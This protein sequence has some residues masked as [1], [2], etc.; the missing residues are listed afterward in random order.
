MVFLI[1]Q[2]IFF[3][4]RLRLR[5]QE[6]IFTDEEIENFTLQKI[7]TILNANNRSLS[8]FPG[9]PQVNHELI[10]FGRNKLIADERRYMVNEERD[11]W[12]TLY[13]GLNTSQKEVY[14]NIMLSVD[15]QNRGL[16]LFMEVVVPVKT[17]L[18]RT[19][20]AQIRS[21]G[22]I[23][24]FVA[25]SGIASLVLSGGRTLH[26]RFRIPVEIDNES[27]CGIDVIS[28]LVE[29]I[30]VSELIIWDEAPLQHRHAF[31][32]VDRTFRDIC[33]LDKPIAETQVLGGKA[34]VLGGDL[35]QILL[36]IKNA[37]RGDVVVASVNKSAAIWGSCR[38]FVLSVN[39]RLCDP[40]LDVADVDQMMCFNKWY[41][42]MGDGTLLAIKLAHEDDATGIT[43]PDDLLIPISDNP[44]TA[45]VSSTYP[46]LSNIINDI[47][48][49]KE[50]C[51]LCPTND[52]VDQINSHELK[53]TPSDLVELYSTDE[54]C[55][56]TENLEEMKIMYPPEF[57]NTLRFSGV[58]NHKLELKV[59]AQSYYYV[60]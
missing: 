46:D 11:L 15:A 52:V 5:N 59:G 9:L 37:R 29:L 3:N 8:N 44:T 45:I 43:I 54:I 23:V 51:I 10:Q 6:V 33:K 40:S 56:T 35:R 30:R 7:E 42:D 41:L 21:L 55:P 25:S 39:M 57:L 36:V 32:S 60:I 28:D 50:R 48:Y 4:Q 26:S 16:F 17:Y 18:W 53:T 49:L 22:K 24:L 27:C 2:K 58:P 14:D 31:E 20:I 12:S 19:I 1:F 38:V 34:M 47:E 13:S